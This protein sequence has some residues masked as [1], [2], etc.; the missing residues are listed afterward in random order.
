MSTA[1]ARTWEQEHVLLVRV[2]KDVDAG[3]YVAE[4]D[5]IPGLSTES[6][7]LDELIVKLKAMIPELLELNDPDED[8]EV[9]IE[10]LMRTA[11][12]HARC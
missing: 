12:Q 3:V 1:Y 8:P 5:D 11:V 6:A 9:P 4:S 7:S 2:T 10:L